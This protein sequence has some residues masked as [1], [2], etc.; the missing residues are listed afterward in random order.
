MV[1]LCDSPTGSTTGENTHRGCLIRELRSKFQCVL[2]NSEMGKTLD[3]II[4]AVVFNRVCH[5]KLAVY[6]QETE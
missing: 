5:A 4:S 3:A 1:Q 6:L 2:P